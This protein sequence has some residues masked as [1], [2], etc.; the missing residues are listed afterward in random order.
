M[1]RRAALLICA[2]LAAVPLAA[3]AADDEMTGG[4]RQLSY[5]VSAGAMVPAGQ[6]GEGLDPG[7]HLGVMIHHESGSGLSLGGEMQWNR[8]TDPLRTGI[9]ALGAIARISPRDYTAA[10]M[11]LGAGAYFVGYSPE[12][13]GTVKPESLIRPGGSFGAG[14][15]AIQMGKFSIG[16][17]AVYHGIL[18][19]SSDALSF[20][21]MSVD[22]TWR[23]YSF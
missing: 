14:F 3:R 9:F 10:F 22:L 8:S 16:A 12:A 6:E 1:K 4:L 13:A 23:P 20:L 11:R 19:E 17:S 15:E 2:A 5:S 7:P 21:T 18:L